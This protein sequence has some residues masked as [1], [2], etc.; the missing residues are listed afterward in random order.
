VV[1]PVVEVKIPAEEEKGLRNRIFIEHGQLWG[2]GDKLQGPSSVSDSK[3]N[4]NL[5]FSEENPE[6]YSSF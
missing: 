1:A 6:Y 4:L 3:T 2:S 5:V